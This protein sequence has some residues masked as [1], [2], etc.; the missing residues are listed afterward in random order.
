M[1]TR[2]A[3]KPTAMVALKDEVFAFYPVKAASTRAYPLP[4]FHIAKGDKQ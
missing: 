1:L 3:P 2:V 4:L